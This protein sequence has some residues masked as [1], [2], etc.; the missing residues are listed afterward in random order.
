MTDTPDL[1][2]AM[3]AARVWWQAVQE[4]EIVACSLARFILEQRAEEAERCSK[5][6]LEPKPWKRIHERPAALRSQ[7]KKENTNL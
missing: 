1:D 2:R 6:H 4:D 7:I 5:L 3:E